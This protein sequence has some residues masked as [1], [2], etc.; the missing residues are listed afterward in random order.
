MYVKDDESWILSAI[1]VAYYDGEDF[2]EEMGNT[3][4]ENT[5]NATNSC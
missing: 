3:K 1:E 4:F 5:T 2:L